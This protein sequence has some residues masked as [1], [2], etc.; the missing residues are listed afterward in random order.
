MGSDESDEKVRT[1][2]WLAVPPPNGQREANGSGKRRSPVSD[3]R[4]RA[5]KL[6]RTAEAVGAHERALSEMRLRLE[7]IEQRAKEAEDRARDANQRAQEAVEREQKLR[8]E[9]AGAHE[10][11]AANTAER[12]ERVENRFEARD[13]ETRTRIA[14]TEEVLGRFPDHA[15]AVERRIQ[16]IEDR[17]A[18]AA[19]SVQELTLRD[20]KRP[21]RAIPPEPSPGTPGSEAEEV[22]VK[23]EAEQPSET[24][25]KLNINKVSFEQLREIGLSVTEAARLLASR[26]ARGAFKSLDELNDL[27]GFAKELVATLRRRLSLS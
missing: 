23:G 5:G 24:T 2:E 8:T 15:R 21:I 16:A 20:A 6:R 11:V 14:R 25:A 26:D 19:A 17:V 13:A 18:A 7:A 27:Q 12:L 10:S 3:R 22:P 4:R 1:S 9:L